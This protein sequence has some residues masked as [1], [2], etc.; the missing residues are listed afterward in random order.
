MCEFPSHT[1][2]THTTS[3]ACSYTNSSH[4]TIKCS[5]FELC[6]LYLSACADLVTS[7]GTLL[8]CTWPLV[9]KMA[10]QEIA[11]KLVT[12]IPERE[13]MA[14]LEINDHLLDFDRC[15]GV[16]SIWYTNRNHHEI[17]SLL[18]QCHTTWA[19]LIF[20]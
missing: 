14:V 17:I 16:V 20:Q 2:H 4:V 6:T 13:A 5:F 3:C 7:F 9:F 11:K 19:I 15:L 18:F 10:S 8:L 12:K 1:P